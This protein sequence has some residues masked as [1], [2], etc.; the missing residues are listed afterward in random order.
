MNP[1]HSK[2]ERLRLKSARANIRSQAKLEPGS[3]K[4][5][6]MLNGVI[7]KFVPTPSTNFQCREN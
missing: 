1:I 3:L 7:A 2:N 5:V 6:E 4:P